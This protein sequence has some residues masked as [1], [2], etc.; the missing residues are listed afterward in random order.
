MVGPAVAGILIAGTKKTLKWQN[1]FWIIASFSGSLASES[2]CSAKLSS[3]ASTPSALARRHSVF[4]ARYAGFTAQTTK[5][6]GLFDVTGE[7]APM[8]ELDRQ[9]RLADD[10]VRHKI[11]RIPESAAGRKLPADAPAPDQVAG[12]RRAP[13][14]LPHP[15]AAHRG[16]AA[17]DQLHDR[18]VRQ[19]ALPH[20][21]LLLWRAGPDRGRDDA[22]P[23]DGRDERAAA[24]G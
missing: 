19:A 3:G 16:W 11:V 24:V 6:H 9:L 21:G 10:V 2:I 1:A 5:S 13:P 15:G 20:A 22:W 23:H 7:P 18:F 14:P 4:G 8:N 12:A 17:G